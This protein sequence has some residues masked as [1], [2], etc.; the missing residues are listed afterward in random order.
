MF[1]IKMLHITI[2]QMKRKKARSIKVASRLQ[3]YVITF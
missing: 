2:K 1:I 3:Q